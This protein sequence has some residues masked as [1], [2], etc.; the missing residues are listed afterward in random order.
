[1]GEHQTTWGRQQSDG[2]AGRRISKTMCNIRSESIES[3]PS[4][5]RDCPAT[6]ITTNPLG[7]VGFPCRIHQAWRHGYPYVSPPSN[8]P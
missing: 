1:M 5:N 7:Q 8:P 3:M 4:L 2:A 6:T